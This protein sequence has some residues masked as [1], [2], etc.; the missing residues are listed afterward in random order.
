MTRRI[1]ELILALA[2]L[3]WGGWLLLPINTF[4]S[5]TT[6]RVL[7][8][9][10]PEWAWGIL[11]VGAGLQLWYGLWQDSY[12]MRRWSL[13]IMAC[14]WLATWGALVIGNWR[15]TATV[16]YIFWVILCAVSYL[17]AGRNGVVA[18]QP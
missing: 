15:S 7:N 17:K 6:F 2:A 12:T 9:T 16:H 11:M 18:P 13:A 14:L 5:S 3:A 10:A 4:E 8:A 1:Y